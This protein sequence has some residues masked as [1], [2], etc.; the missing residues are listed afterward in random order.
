MSYDWFAAARRLRAMAQTGLTYT[1]GHFDRERYEELRSTAEAML[2]EVLERAPHSVR[3]AYALEQ[4]YPTPKIDVRAA[5]FSERRI[6]LVREVEDGCWTLPGGW[7]DVGDTP[8]E[9]TERETL[10]ESGFVVRATRLIAIKDRSRHA[11][12]PQQVH[13][14]YKLFFLADLLGGEAR[15]SNETTGV[16]FFA[17]D[18]LPELSAGRTLRADIEDAFEALDDPARLPSFD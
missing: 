5:V 18:A 3:D 1:T 15:T 2:A 17:R 10:E 4:G 8:R 6:L 14:I 9:A 7:A 13:S 12:Q 16:D 11:Y